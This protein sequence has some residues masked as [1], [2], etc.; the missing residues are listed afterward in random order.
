[1]DSTYQTINGLL[2]EALWADRMSA[3]RQV[4][5]FT[6]GRGKKKPDAF[7]RQ[8]LE[9]IIRR[10]ERSRGIRRR[11]IK[12]LPRLTFD[13]DLPIC[14]KKDDIVEKIKAHQVL[15]VSGETG[16]GKTT[17]LP[18]FC[19]AA[20]RGIDGVIGCT[21]PRRI[22]A[23]TVSQRIAAEL[24]QPSGESVGYK[25][26]F[27]DKSA[28]HAH[29]KLMTDG[30]LLAETQVDPWLNEYDTIIVDEAHERSLNIDFVLGILK[31]LIARRNNLKLII[32]SAT[33]DTQ[34][35]SAA[36]GDAPVVEVSG[37][38]FPVKTHYLPPEAGE[39]NGEDSLHVEQAIS[40]LD[41]IISQS[42]FGDVLIFM[43]TEQDIRETIEL[44]SGRK[45]KNIA[46]LP[47]F[48]RLSAAEQQKVFDRPEGRKIIVATNVAETSL[49]IP[50]IKYVIDS[51]LAR[52][53][54]YNPITRTTAL[55]VTQISRSSA[56]QRMGRCGR[57]QNGVCY[58]LYRE[59]DYQN[60]PRFTVPEILRS[61]LAEV[62]LR[63]IA[64]NLGNAE[65]F[66]FID[67]PVAK[68]I[69]DGTRILQELDAITSAPKDKRKRGRRS[70]GRFQLTAKGR[71]MA[72]LPLDPRLARML[73]QGEQENCLAE[74][75]VL[76]AALSIQD[77]KERPLEKQAEADQ[78]HAV[79]ADH[80]SD[81]LGLLNIWEAYQTVRR[82]QKG[83]GKVKAFCRDH[84]LSFRRMREWSDIH[85]QIVLLLEEEGFKI[86]S[87]RSRETTGRPAE[88]FSNIG[89]DP[90]YAAI[91]RA[92]L[93]G[94]L[95]NIAQKKEKQ[96]YR[97]ARDREAM[98]FP[99]S[100][101]FKHPGNWIVAAEMVE[102][103][104]LFA[105]TAGLIDPAWLEELGQNLCRYSYSDPRWYRSQANVLVKEQ[106]ALFGLVIVSNRPVIYGRIDPPAA[107][108]IFIREALV[109]GDMVRPLSFMTHNQ[110]LI[111]E[112]RRMEDR[113]RRRDIL[114][115]ED[116]IVQFYHERLEGIYDLPGLKKRIRQEGGDQFLRMTRTQLL[117]SL[118]SDEE[119]SSYPNNVSLGNGLYEL[120]YCFNP[121]TSDDG[122][123]ISIP[124][125][126]AAT[127]S[128][129]GL[130]WLVPGLLSEKI[131][132]LIKG[133]PKN[134][135][136]QLV[137]IAA[138]VDTV[139]Q[140]M[141]RRGRSLR[142]SLS[143]FIYQRFGVD[144]PAS[145]WPEDRLPDHLRMRIAVTDSKGDIIC[146][147]R[148][149]EILKNVAGPRRKD[150]NVFED[151]CRTWERRDLSEFPEESIPESIPVDPSDPAQGNAYPALWTDGERACLRVFK[152]RLAAI[153]AHP[154]GVARLLVRRFSR[155]LKFLKHNLL[156]P[157]DARDPAIYFGGYRSVEAS[158]YESTVA[159]LFDR[160]LRTQKAYEDYAQQLGRSG[161]HTFG[162]EK[163]DAVCK[164]LHGYQTA[165][166]RLVQL[167]SANRANPGLQS[168]LGELQ[169]QLDQLLPANFVALYDARR[170]GQMLRYLTA[171]DIRAQRA[172]VNLDKDRQRWAEIEPF[173]NRLQGLLTS[174]NSQSSAEK[175][176]A[177]ETF[178]WMTEE[179]KISLFAQE[180]G[181]DGPI[182]AKRLTKKLAEI[183]RMV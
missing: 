161:L 68:N 33:I 83:W 96:F 21:Q 78:A 156:L 104:R 2:G 82:T 142:T 71:L 141:P 140:E 24:G 113:V 137:P 85:A 117:A 124:N 123:T 6:L 38:M 73:I 146:A 47:L 130:D 34:K 160:N 90:V 43:P 166:S 50:G 128:P 162:S 179:F 118:P 145:A 175:R 107:S 30:I 60:R 95:S 32:T 154:K 86:S 55:P 121:Q 4:K 110:E 102:T 67:A 159:A 76:A 129:E 40:V 3:E 136:K 125:S 103:S 63:M 52:I 1:M 72:K 81:F 180:V 59:D 70:R 139:L 91:H 143:R 14:A 19:L 131:T 181:T 48:A 153:K 88:A 77:P 23:I 111:E 147:D 62:I 41:R 12:A 93:S 116:A 135:R 15:I 44:I 155:E 45:Y 7:K 89:D 87:V 53:S 149:P 164:V 28:P 163:R 54:Q 109:S 114:I 64:L 42:P 165:R 148:N 37:R 10:L 97:A 157:Q 171:L 61:N 177:L 134:Y 26:R 122:V 119:L 75:I 138:T 108:T 49:T 176:A 112:L 151:L 152:D 167:A 56:D 20:G 100:S 133:L 98:I 51:G 99:G 35:F 132:A 18:K 172:V 46:V 168:L 69:A 17:Q 31:S 170:L 66:P 65:D 11:K 80:R 94:F 174:L 16:S 25:I 178:Y 58:R 127:V 126:E 27:Q 92:I 29:I 120:S 8:R 106:V 158:L 182:S 22:A 36:F 13:P 144:V 57:V 105:R 183:E 9:E 169:T 79:F 5:Y 101:L 39:D 84:F 173:L 74:I 150:S 115:A